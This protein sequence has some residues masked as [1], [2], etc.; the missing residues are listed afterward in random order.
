MLHEL[1]LHFKD[2][3]PIRNDVLIELGTFLVRRWSGNRR[4]V[5]LM[6][7][8]KTPITKLDKNQIV[9]PS[10]KF[11]QGNEFQKYRQWRI[12]LWYESMR[13]AHSDKI[14]SHD[15][16]FGKI[17]NSLEFRRVETLGLI[18]W[19]GMEQEVI[20]NEGISWW[21]RPMLNS[22]Y[23]RQKI[24]EAYI[25]YLIT[26]YSKGELFG[27]EFDR[28]KE[29]VNYSNNILEKA[30]INKYRTSWMENHVP[31]IIKILQIDP[32]VTIPSIGLK[33]RIGIS[34]NENDLMKQVE[35]ILLTKHK[36]DEESVDKVLE[37]KQLQ[38]EFE[39]LV[40]ETRKNESKGYSSLEHLGLDL[41]DSSGIDES[42]IYDTDLINKLKL[43]VRDW[44]TGWIETH[45][46]NGD[47]LDVDVVIE[48]QQKPFFADYKNTINTKVTMLVDHSSSIEDEQ[49]EYKKATVAICEALN[50]LKIRFSVYA[51]NTKDRKVKCWVVKPPE[52]KWSP[53]TARNLVNI[54]ASGGTPLAEIY[55]LLLPTVKIFRPDIM[56]TLTDGEPSDYDSVRSIISTYRLAQIHMVAVGVG[57]NVN[58]AINIG[59]NLKDLGFE[60]TLAVS[61]IQD[62]PKRVLSL[63]EI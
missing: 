32:L 60:K 36:M 27:S 4:V 59:H 33:S 5:V 6:S 48:G 55:Q 21:Y 56:I 7:D 15:I 17:L 40:R 30:F 57:H 42:I 44:K 46:D 37:G 3:L 26:G 25:Q 2:P 45:E 28:V 38:K 18:E 62:I 14:M 23:G 35:K 19:E 1:T 51:F 41:P 47:D 58:D 50:Y 43:V 34:I 54:G 20:F 9:M 13:L 12:A 52:L 53:M 22:L 39:S 61:R 49:L 16:A 24:V 8:N 31:Q 63:L 11:Y 10:L 29:A